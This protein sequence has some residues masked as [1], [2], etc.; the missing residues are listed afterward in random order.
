MTAE[1]P[2]QPKLCGAGLRGRPGKTCRMAPML[3]GR[4]RLHGGL[5]TGPRTWKAG[6][7]YSRALG[8]GRLQE[9]FL[10]QL[11]ADDILDTAPDLALLS[12]TVHELVE[13]GVA[14]RDTPEF[15]KRAREL[16]RATDKAQRGSSDDDP[17]T[18]MADL[19]QLLE[20]GYASD[21]ALLE[22][23]DVAVERAKRAEAAR[24]LQLRAEESITMQQFAGVLSIIYRVIQHHCR[25]DAP[26]II[27]DI[28]AAYLAPE[29]RL[30]AL[31]DVVGG[32]QALSS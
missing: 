11:E 24:G 26:R 27:G 6:G 2:T 17:A 1:Q 23:C 10:G 20:D 8:L 16:W 15:R 30:P 12:T 22:A 21:R 9:V 3:N 29:A 7:R 32:A 19:G 25:D 28:R 5:S 4:C 31:V 14:Q 18:L 13:K